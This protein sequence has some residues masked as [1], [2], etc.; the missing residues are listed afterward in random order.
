MQKTPSS[1]ETQLFVTANKLRRWVR[2]GHVSRS[3]VMTERGKLDKKDAS[4]DSLKT[5]MR[6]I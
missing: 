2:N 5:R 1:I 3:V 4:C 6:L